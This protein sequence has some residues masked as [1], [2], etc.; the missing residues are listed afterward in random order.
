MRLKVEYYFMI[1]PLLM[2]FSCDRIS[3]KINVL[4]ITGGHPYDT[5]AFVEMFRSLGNI[6]FDTMSQP[7]ANAFIAAGGAVKF[8]VLVFYDMW[9][10]ISEGEK[11]AYRK[12]WEEGKGMVFL[13]HSLVSYSNWDE[14]GDAIG[15]RYHL[16][17][18]VTDTLKAS[19]YRHDITL[20][21]RVLDPAHPVTAGL[22][23][24]TTRDEGYSNIEIKP[25]VHYLLGTD[26]PDCSE[27]VGWTNVHR[28]SRIIY[29]MQG[30]DSTAYAN[31]SL[32]KLLG[33]SIYWVAGCSEP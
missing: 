17:E 9:Q 2:F 13:H 16:A 27:Y 24:F 8:D 33:N 4:V 3:D 18:N 21:V 31:E 14:F 30:H 6:D 23:D 1:I 22:A 15:G 32:K 5:G 11:E 10:Q 29:L 19:N 7:G 12:L 20:N 28:N 26:H 25:S